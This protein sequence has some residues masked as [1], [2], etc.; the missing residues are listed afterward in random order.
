MLPCLARDVRPIHAAAPH[1]R[2]WHGRMRHGLGHCAGESLWGPHAPQLDR[3]SHHAGACG[4]GAEPGGDGGGRRRRARLGRRR[5]RRRSRRRGRRAWR[6]LGPRSVAA[7]VG[8]MPG[9]PRGAVCA[10][11]GCG[12]PV[13]DERQPGAG[14]W[15][16]ER[17]CF[18]CA[19]ETHAAHTFNLQV[20]G[21]TRA[22]R[23]PTVRA[24]MARP[25]R[26]RSPPP[27]VR[28]PC[29]VRH[30]SRGLRV[31][32]TLNAE[33]ACVAP[34][35]PRC[36][37][38]RTAGAPATSICELRVLTSAAWRRATARCAS[39]CCVRRAGLRRAGGRRA[40]TGT[41]MLLLRS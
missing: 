17:R 32:D 28:V 25:R 2:A 38:T 18:F 36:G 41:T 22:E 29:A 16:R 9:A 33:N 3:T 27:C 4:G 31:S 40:A 26:R 34:A 35:A 11:P 15:Q 19:P 37:S 12:V 21:C 7:Y 30:D 39:R 24:C 6:P 13:A 10:V 14:M 5:R 1:W 8:A 20:P 23:T